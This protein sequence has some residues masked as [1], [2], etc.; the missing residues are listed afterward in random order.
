MTTVTSGMLIIELL[1]Y[2][3]VFGWFNTIL[4]LVLGGC[5]RKHE[6]EGNFTGAFYYFLGVTVTTASF[7]NSFTSLGI[8]QLALADPSA[9]FFG[10]N[11]KDMYWSRIENGFFGFGRNREF[12]LG[13]ALCCFPFNYRMLS[14]AKFGGTDTILGGQLNVAIAS[15][16]LGVA[17]IPVF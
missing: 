2:Q 8:R 6:M 13:G 7:P 3:K 16:A 11:T 1:R 12:L 5:L 4:I 17:D 15:L 10:R 14:V 9:S